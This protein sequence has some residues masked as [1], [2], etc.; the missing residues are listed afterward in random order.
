MTKRVHPSDLEE[1]NKRIKAQKDRFNKIE[2]VLAHHR[3][4]SAS[5]LADCG[6]MSPPPILI[7]DDDVDPS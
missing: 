7:A 5:C 6:S 3:T 1:S 4:L 2:G